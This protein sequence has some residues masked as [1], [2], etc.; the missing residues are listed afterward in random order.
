MKVEDRLINIGNMWK[1]KKD[2][3]LRDHI[4]EID[5]RAY[6][7]ITTINKCETERNY[8]KSIISHNQAM[9]V[10]KN[11]EERLKEH[12]DKKELMLY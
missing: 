2:N 12:M 1:E 5:S 9:K 10:E 3:Q 11:F 6:P 7:V 8:N 4:Q